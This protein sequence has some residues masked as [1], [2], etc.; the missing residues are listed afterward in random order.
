[1][2]HKNA[3]YV[4]SHYDAVTV[5]VPDAPRPAELLIVV[6]GATGS[7]PQARVGGLDAAE[8]AGDG[9]R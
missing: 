9:L 3:L 6:A 7:R 4:R 2:A 1:L 8:I 5:T